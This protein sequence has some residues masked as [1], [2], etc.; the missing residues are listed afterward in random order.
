MGGDG[1]MG[2][3]GNGETVMKLVSAVMMVAAG[4]S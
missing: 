1:V 4:A 2:G 3:C